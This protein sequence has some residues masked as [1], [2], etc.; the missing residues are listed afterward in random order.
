MS[1]PYQFVGSTVFLYQQARYAQNFLINANKTIVLTE[2]PFIIKEE[3]WARNKFSLHIN[4]KGFNENGEIISLGSNN[5]EIHLLYTQYDYFF[6]KRLYK[7][8][9]NTGVY[10]PVAN[11]KKVA[12]N[13]PPFVYS[14]KLR[15]WGE[16]T[17]VNETGFVWS[18]KYMGKT[19]NFNVS[20]YDGILNDYFFSP[21]PLET[22]LS[23]LPTEI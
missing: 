5:S 11:I 20:A 16:V 9:S 23:R 4:I 6:N 13:L 18:T 2:T 12:V 8:Y 1:K 10:L 17:A 19:Q 14:K 22:V 15:E 7:F 21:A 3:T